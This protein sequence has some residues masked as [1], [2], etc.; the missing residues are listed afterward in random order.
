MF[1]RR[2]RLAA[3]VALASVL[4]LVGAQFAV[5][6]TTKVVRGRLTDSGYRWRPKLAEVAPGTRVIWRSV[7]GNHTVTSYGAGWSIDRTISQGERTSFTFNN[8]GTFRYV[9]E[10]HGNVVGGNCT[11]MCGKVRV[12]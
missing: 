4:T 3:I 8:S 1:D 12:G 11:G 6:G 5:A 2:R 7:E 10:I 9:C